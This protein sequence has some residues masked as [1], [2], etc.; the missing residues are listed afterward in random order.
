MEKSLDDL[1]DFNVMGGLDFMT[2]LKFRDDQDDESTEL[3]R[4]IELR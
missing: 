2:N 1:L 3:K 4:E